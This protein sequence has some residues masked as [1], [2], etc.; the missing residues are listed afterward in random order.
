MW[1][2]RTKM[3]RNQVERTIREIKENKYKMGTRKQMMTTNRWKSQRTTG[4]IG[5]KEKK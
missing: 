4:S 2:M 5:I 3:R 1:Q